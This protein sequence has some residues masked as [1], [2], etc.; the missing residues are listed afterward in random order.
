MAGL[1]ISNMY[2]G[3]YAVKLLDDQA[4]NQ[5]AGIPDLVQAYAEKTGKSYANVFGRWVGWLAFDDSEEEDKCPQ[6]DGCPAKVGRILNTW[7]CQAPVIEPTEIVEDIGGIVF[8][9]NG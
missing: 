6:P 5:I 1:V 7:Y 4:W 9:P 8:L 2:G 3:E